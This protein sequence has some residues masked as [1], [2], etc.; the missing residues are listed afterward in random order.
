M[1]KANPP[2]STTASP[3]AQSSQTR[4]SPRHTT[5]PALLFAFCILHFAFPSCTNSIQEINEVTGK[6]RPGEDHGQDVTIL[7]STGGRVHARLFSHTFIRN[8]GAN[9]PYA[10]MK[11][12]LKAEFF[13]D[14][15]VVRSTLT[16][17]YARWY[18]KENN[19]LIRDSVHVINDKGEQLFT[20]EL[21][22]N[23]RLQKFFT[24]KPVR[25]V[26]PTQTLIG[27]GM[28]ANQDFSEYS[29]TNI[30]GSVQVDK[31]Q[32]PVE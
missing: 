31:S 12:G 22:W 9:P 19:I 27:T 21:V 3:K 1:T 6:A 8:N 2:K 24:E 30:R 20:N 4:T 13:N 17:R 29:F 10:E 15:T 32:M 25:I 28:E 11:D 16:A 18:E 26:T 5:K 7:Y 14:S 23:Q